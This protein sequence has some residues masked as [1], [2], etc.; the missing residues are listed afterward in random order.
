ME[1]YFRRW[2][3]KSGPKTLTNKDVGCGDIQM[4]KA[5]YDRGIDDVNN[6]EIR[7]AYDNVRNR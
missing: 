6:W 1:V 4:V 7:K 2:E 5:Q 3:Y